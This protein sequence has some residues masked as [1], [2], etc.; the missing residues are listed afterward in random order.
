M[1]SATPLPQHDEPREDA[2]VVMREAANDTMRCDDAQTAR[3][4]RLLATIWSVIDAE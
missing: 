1:S 3:Q 2:S 4:A